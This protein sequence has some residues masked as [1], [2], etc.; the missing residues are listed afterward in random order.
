[1]NFLIKNL[2]LILSI[3]NLVV[4]VS[5][6]FLRNRLYMEGFVDGVVEL[7]EAAGIK[8]SVETDTSTDNTDDA[9]K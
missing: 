7:A 3:I 6:Y 9:N 2:P 8:V 4:L 1:M 5:L